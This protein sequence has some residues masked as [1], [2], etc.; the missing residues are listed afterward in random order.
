MLTIEIGW[1]GIPGKEI[2]FIKGR[3]FRK[4]DACLGHSEF[5][6]VAGSSGMW[7]GWNEMGPERR[8]GARLC[9]DYIL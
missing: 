1:L 4:C 8:V 7:G 6:I 2:T 9:L 3:K 5:S